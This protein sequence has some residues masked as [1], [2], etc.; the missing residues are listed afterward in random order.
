M[1]KSRDICFATEINGPT[2]G[3]KL[4]YSIQTR[5]LYCTMI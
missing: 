5:M 2:F 1:S 3:I 4:W